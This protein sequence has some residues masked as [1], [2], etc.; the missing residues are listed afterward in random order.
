MFHSLLLKLAAWKEA[1]VH[2]LHEVEFSYFPDLHNL[3]TVAYHKLVLGEAWQRF[4]HHHGF[5]EGFLVAWRALQVLLAWGN[6]A[7][8]LARL[9]IFLEN[10]LWL[11]L[12]LVFVRTG[13]LM[14]FDCPPSPLEALR[15]F[16]IVADTVALVRFLRRRRRKK[17]EEVIRILDV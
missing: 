5:H 10:L 11:Y 15:R 3:G 8:I 16:P 12:M 4:L 17:R 9:E 6:E 1:L 2:R 13:Y 7:F 14:F